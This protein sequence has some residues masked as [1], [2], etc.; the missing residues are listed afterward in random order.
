[1]LPLAT[2]A[3]QTLAIVTVI[4]SWSE[5]MWPL[6]VTTRAEDMPASVGIVSLGTLHDPNYPQVMAAAVMTLAPVLIG[7][8]LLHRRVLAGVSLGAK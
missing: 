6:V 8:I 3:L 2:P 7:F 5:L 4:W 1:M